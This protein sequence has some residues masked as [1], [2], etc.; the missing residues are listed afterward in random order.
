MC[1]DVFEYGL[2]TLLTV[3]LLYFG[4]FTSNIPRYLLDFALY[5]DEDVKGVNFQLKKKGTASKH[6]NM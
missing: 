1:V 4:L 5:F 3:G 2:Y 6:G